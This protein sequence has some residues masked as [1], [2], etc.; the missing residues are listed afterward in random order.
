[1][2]N[3]FD[4]ATIITMEEQFGCQQEYLSAD[5]GDLEQILID[6]IAHGFKW[7]ES[8]SD[9]SYVEHVNGGLFDDGK[10]IIN[11]KDLESDFAALNS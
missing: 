11:W 7:D 3:N 6:C 1:M 4:L 9:S 2:Q 5:D 10:T 8:F